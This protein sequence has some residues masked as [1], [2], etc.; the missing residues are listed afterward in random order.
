M[1][2]QLGVSIVAASLAAAMTST[3]YPGHGFI[4]YGIDM[5]HP[6]CAFACHDALSLY[7]LSCSVAVNPEDADGNHLGDMS[8]PTF[9]TS[10]KCYATDDN[11]LQSVAYCIST[12]CH[13]VPLSDLE[14]Y[15]ATFLIGR[16]PG[17]PVPKESYST[18]L[19][20]A[21]PPPT[22]IVA[23]M[24]LLNTTTLMEARQSDFGLVLLIT[25]AV[26]PVACSLLRFV[27]L[28]STLVNRFNAYF[29]DPPMFGR[30]HREPL[31]NIALV[32][33]R[34][35][36]LLIA[37]FTIINVVLSC[38]DYR[39]V[40]PN[41]FY[42]TP[43]DQL[44][45]YITNRQGLLSFANLPLL[46]LYSSRNNILLWITNWS[47]TTFLLLH[48][49]I[50]MI[51]TIEACLHSAIYLHIYLGFGEHASESKQ[52]YWEWGI[53]ATLAMSILLPASVLPIRQKLY[54]VFLTSHFILAFIALIG[55]YY[56]IY[57]R[58]DHQWGY[59]TWLHIASAIWA[60]DKIARFARLARNGI[61]TAQITVI[62][63]DYIRVDIPDVV[64]QGHAYLYFTRLSWRVWKMWE[65]HPYSVMGVMINEAAKGKNGETTTLNI[66]VMD[67]ESPLEQ[68]SA[69]SE[70]FKFRTQ[71]QSAGSFKPGLTFFIR[72]AKK[73][74]TPFL[75]ARSTARVMVESSYPALSL[76]ELRAA[77]NCI[78]IAGGVGITAVGPL[79]RA[80]GPGRVRFFWGVR[81]KQLVEAVVNAL[82]VDVFTPSIVGEI[83]VGSRL[84]LRA[85]LEREVVGDSETVV[86]VCG[87]VGMADEARQVVCELGRQGRNVRLIDE[88]Y[89]W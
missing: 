55:C 45:V 80:R 73:G 27:P 1:R 56:H 54:N 77:P 6:T 18:A 60:F 84:N 88:A 37:Y 87:P 52:P 23:P 10:P 39:L 85:I 12:H 47:Q 35:Q 24:L 42:G 49:W 29:I 86:V 66:T 31:F 63:E 5:Y 25:G 15:W 30:R 40:S 78:V 65:N 51:C 32:P 4:G 79:L 71:E 58:Y 41:A 9:T 7:K 69:T 67:K 8:M 28:P 64:A 70:L 82:G 74:I 16:I 89:S 33:S 19:A 2:I 38:I 50:A 34:G 26:I 44:L 68:A 22:K 17:Q 48:R 46:I 59:E 11:F 20:H 36:A 13:D 14:Y 76:G 53:V 72:T 57:R 61:R 75:R 43:K 62:D 81:S 21:D 83:A 3:G